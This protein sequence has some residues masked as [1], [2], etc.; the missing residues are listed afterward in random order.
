MADDAIIRSTLGEC[1]TIA[2]GFPFRGAVDG[3]EEGSVAVIQMRNVD[4][5]SG[6]DWAALATVDLPTKRQPDLLASGDVIL[7]TRGRRYFAL[8][9]SKIPVPT[10]CSPHFFVIRAH[11]VPALLPEFLAWQINQKPAQ[12]YLQQAATG[13]HILNLTRGA[14]AALPIMIPSMHTQKAAVALADAAQREVAAL[15][16]LID[17]RRAELDAVATQILN[18]E[19]LS[20]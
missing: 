2:A 10:V 3:L 4:N 6:V 5:T 12:E 8:A 13:S 20:A 16:A 18:T 14:V 19:R 15:Q 17:N 11:A 9:L 1:A 7:T